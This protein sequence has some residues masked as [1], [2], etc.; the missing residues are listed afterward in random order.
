MTDIIA[1]DDDPSGDLAEPL[2]EPEWRGSKPHQRV[3]NVPDAAG[4]YSERKTATTSWQRSILII[5]AL[6][7]LCWAVVI[8]VLIAI[9]SAV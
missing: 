3:P 6:S 7:A 8:F 1:N 5:A 4:H 2:A 9:F